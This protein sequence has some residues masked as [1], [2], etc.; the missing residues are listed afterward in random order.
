MKRMTLAI[1]A[2]LLMLVVSGNCTA[3]PRPTRC[4]VLIHVPFAFQVAGRTFPAGYYQFEQ[5]LGKSDG[6]EILVV[7]GLD[8][9]FYQAVATKAE[10]MDETE[11]A[12]KLVF[13]HSGEQLV[14]VALCSHSKH[15][16]IE[17]YDAG[18]K[19][20][21]IAARTEG[22]DDVELAVPSDGDLLAMARPADSQTY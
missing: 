19:Q 15:T 18:T 11:P 17:L 6:V 21:M 22:T 7:R 16:S 1:L 5:I 3:S 4:R 8:Q 9:Q 2:T 13:R 10:K 14:L 20:P 12:S